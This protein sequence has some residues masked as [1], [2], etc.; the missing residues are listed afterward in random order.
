MV[1]AFYGRFIF[2][3]FFYVGVEPINNVVIVS[4]GRQRDSVVHIHV[5]I[6]LQIPLPSSLPHN[7]E[8]SFRQV[9]LLKTVNSI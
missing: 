4:G 7:T 3:F 8:Q 6:L 5:S 1:I 9:H 2:N